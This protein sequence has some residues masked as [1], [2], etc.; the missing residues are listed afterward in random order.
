MNLFYHMTYDLCIS[1]S[2]ARGLRVH[3]WFTTIGFKIFLQY[4]V[5]FS[6]GGGFCLFARA[7]LSIGTSP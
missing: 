4:L 3:L 5:I 6:V 7:A 2:R 1:N